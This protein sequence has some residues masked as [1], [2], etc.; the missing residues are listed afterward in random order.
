MRSGTEQSQ[1]LRVF[2]PFFNRYGHDGH[3]EFRVMT[4]L[5]KSSRTIIKMP[6]MKFH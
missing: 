2:L 5:A 1:F 6:N 3:L 4:F